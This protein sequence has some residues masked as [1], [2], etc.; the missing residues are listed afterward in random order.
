MDKNV[1]QL[2]SSNSAME[3]TIQTL[4]EGQLS[5]DNN[6]KMLMLKMGIN[7][8]ATDTKQQNKSAATDTVANQRD[9]WNDTHS[10]DEAMHDATEFDELTETVFDAVLQQCAS[11]KN[12]NLI[13]PQKKLKT[14]DSLS[15]RPGGSRLSK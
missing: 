7:T 15:L 1:K 8:N 10:G 12:V 3:T 4:H 9:T 11:V 2:T 13:S 14:S 6:I 5:M